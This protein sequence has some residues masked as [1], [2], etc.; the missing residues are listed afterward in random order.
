MHPSVY[1]SLTYDSQDM[2]TIYI[3]IERGID[4]E[5][6]AHLYSGILLRHKKEW[7]NVICSNMDGP[8]DY[9]TKWS[10]SD[11]KKTN[12]IWYHL[13][14]ESNKSDTKKTYL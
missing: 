9:H 6:V 7:T 11:R 12:I 14:V 4:K 10:N 3:S 5:D 13:D 1:C 2:D 8:R